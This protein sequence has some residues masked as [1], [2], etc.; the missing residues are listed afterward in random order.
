MKERL[1]A[2][3]KPISLTCEE[4]KRAAKDW[5]TSRQGPVFQREQNTCLTYFSTVLTLFI[6]EHTRY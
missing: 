2:E 3:L 1:K 6:L 5:K 4:A